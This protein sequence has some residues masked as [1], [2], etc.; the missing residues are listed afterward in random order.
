MLV[1]Q[2]V[3]AYSVEQDR[4]RAI[5]PSGFDSLRPVLRINAEIQDKDMGYLEF[6]TAVEKDGNRGW[7]NIA[8]WN[9]VSFERTGKTV[10]FK[11]SFLEI[12]FTTVGIEGSCP[13]EKDNDGC[14]FIK[15]TEIIRKPECIA[16][17]K[18]F[19]DCEFKWTFSENDAY[20]KSI[21]KTIPAIPTEI[22][23]IYPKEIFTVEN[24]A[25]ILCR[26]VLG[27][28]LVIFDRE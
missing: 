19:C 8:Y 4:L 3:M 6:N 14:Y 25:K 28:Y 23:K 7:L 11:T 21:G 12:S 15:D 18:E 24:A 17:N 16:S 2:F 27:A 26:Q 9:D 13:A 1:E 5:L 10:A 22:I 20:G